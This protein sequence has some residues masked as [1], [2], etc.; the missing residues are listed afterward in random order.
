MT[1]G[2]GLLAAVLRE[3]DS[4]SSSSRWSAEADRLK[5][6]EAIWKQSCSRTHSLWCNCGNWTAHIKLC[7]TGAERGGRDAGG[8]DGL[9][10]GVNMDAGLE[11]E[12]EDAEK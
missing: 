11:F 8:G 3:N 2:S 10:G 12:D 5:R 4:D 9:P 7:D 6:H 1:D